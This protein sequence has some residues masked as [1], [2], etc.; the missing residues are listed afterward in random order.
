MRRAIQICKVSSGDTFPNAHPR[1]MVSGI[2]MWKELLKHASSFLQS[3]SGSFFKLLRK[4]WD[5]FS[6]FV[7]QGVSSLL[8]PDLDAKTRAFVLKFGA[9]G[10]TELE[11]RAQRERRE[12]EQAEAAAAVAAKKASSAKESAAAEKT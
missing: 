1:H 4:G 8:M 9:R 11:E 2:A 5:A 3:R 7:R 6:N 10:R 12:Q